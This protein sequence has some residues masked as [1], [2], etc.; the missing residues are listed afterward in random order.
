VKIFSDGVPKKIA[1]ILPERYRG[2][3][4]RGAVN[5][6]RMLVLGSREAGVE[7]DVSFGH[8]DEPDTYSES[9]FDELRELGIKVRPFK[10]ECIAA[11]LLQ[12]ILGYLGAQ[13]PAPGVTHYWTFNDGISNF[14]ECDFWIIVSDRIQYPMPPHRP[15][16]IVAYDYIQRYVPYI[17]GLDRKSEDNWRMFDG[18]AEV[19]RNAQFVICNTDQG[20]MDCINYTGS[21]A[22][23]VFKFPVEFDPLDFDDLAPVTDESAKP[24]LL[25]TTNSTQHKNHLN[26]IAG[27]ETYF[28]KFPDSDL[29]VR[30][31]GVYTHLFSSSGSDDPH[32]SYEYP[33]KVRKALANSPNLKR[34]LR[35]L[36]IL[37]DQEYTDQLRRSYGVLHG[38]LYDNGTYAILEAAW[39]GIPSISSEYPAITETCINFDLHPMLFNPHRPAELARAV[40][41]FIEQ[42]AELTAKLPNRA[43][44]SV[45]TFSVVA[46]EYWNAFINAIELTSAQ[47]HV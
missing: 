29:E 12:P 17:F 15:Y 30:V 42:H 11:N 36:G 43:R 45:R 8:M 16:A 26:I 2:G 19:T 6:S 9:E 13:K 37:S 47:K 22:N 7:L 21:G 44:L 24:Y 35:V 28:R 33:T 1:V 32:Y 14:E 18:F 38:A 23:H 20:R 3:T 4:L 34:R 41:Q 46:P 31:T 5:I 25:W 40:E 10:R 39:H 27:L